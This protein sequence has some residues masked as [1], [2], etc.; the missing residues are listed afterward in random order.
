MPTTVFNGQGQVGNWNDTLNWAGHVLPGSTAIALLN[1]IGPETFS[2][3]ISV[4]TIMLLGTSSVAFNGTVNTSGEGF[5]RGIM[6]CN[7]GTMT[8]NAG[9]TLN[10]LAGSLNI[11]VHAVGSFTAKGTAGSPTVIN[12][13]HALVGQFAQG[14]GTITI[15][16]ATWNASGLAV[17]GDAGTGSLDVRDGGQVNI[18]GNLSVAARDGSVGNITVEAG[19]TMTVAGNAGLGGLLADQSYGTATV[20]INAGGTLN[21]GHSLVERANSSIVLKGGAVNLGTSGQ[22][23]MALQSGGSISGYGT[24]SSANNLLSDAGV[25]KAQGGTLEINSNVGGAGNIDIA[26]NS[27]VK[28]DGSVHVSVID[29]TG[30]NGSLELQGVAPF[31][32]QISDFAAGDKIVFDTMIDSV[33]WQ[34]GS[35]S[36]ALSSGGHVVETLHLGG[37][38]TNAMFDLHTVAGSSIITL[39]IS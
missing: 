39:H 14:V 29:F 3:P 20:T 17:I 16:D 6:V 10:D 28:L 38:A 7:G 24:L 18:G 26:N 23:G 19:S 35:G 22:G 2:G 37:I 11:G 4:G 32:S 31:T 8:F 9:S 15:D 12:T 5:C 36:L 1:G 34:P 27:T 30:T 25:I 13:A 33:K 21:I